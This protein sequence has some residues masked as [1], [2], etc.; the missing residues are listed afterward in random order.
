MSPRASSIL[1]RRATGERPYPVLNFPEGNSGKETPVAISEQAMTEVDPHFRKG[2]QCLLVLMGQ[3]FLVKI[4]N[5]EE[6]RLRLSFPAGDFPI[7]GMYVDLEFH[8]EDGYVRYESEVLEGPV[9]VGDGVLVRRPSNLVFNRHREHWRVPADFKAELKGHVH[10]RRHL[11]PVIN[12]S[13]GG[14][15]VRSTAD[16]SMGDGLEIELAIPGG[17]KNIMTGQIV[18]VNVTQGG[19]DTAHFYGIKF[20]GMDP[21]IAREIHAYVRQ[22]VRDLYFSG[23]RMNLRRRSDDLTAK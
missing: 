6:E 1:P 11:V 10:P 22:R 14:L 4:L 16:F 15:L 20:I 8:D 5:V 17:G 21:Q 2:G 12:I 19:R 23:Q 7:D 9:N 13:V 18:H 3:R